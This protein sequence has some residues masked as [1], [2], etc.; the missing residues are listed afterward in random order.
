MSFALP[1]TPAL[2]L[3]HR[4]NEMGGDLEGLREIVETVV[5][6]CDYSEPLLRQAAEA[7][8][9]EFAHVLHEMANSSSI[10]GASVCA[11]MARNLEGRLASGRP[12]VW[13]ASCDA[14]VSEWT[15]VLVALNRWLH[16]V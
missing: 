1:S 10:I 8:G 11:A 7:G 12:V 13:S 6:E 15:A 14:L 9:D 16:A 3:A 4:L 2:D 5:N